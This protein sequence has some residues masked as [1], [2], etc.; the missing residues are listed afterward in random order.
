MEDNLDLKEDTNE[1]KKNN[2]ETNVLSYNP[3]NEASND[4][5][6]DT[7]TSLENPFLDGE[8]E[9]IKA[10]DSSIPK[11]SSTKAKKQKENPP[12]GPKNVQQLA[13]ETIQARANKV[14]QNLISSDQ[15]VVEGDFV[16]G[17]NLKLVVSHFNPLFS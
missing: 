2:V 1:A 11:Q 6:D 7:C 9:V 8:I 12:S 5:V 17:F 4:M 14:R 13:L 10:L 3:G 15:R 16:S